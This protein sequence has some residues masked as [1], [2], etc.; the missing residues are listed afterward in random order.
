MYSHALKHTKFSFSV[1]AA[2]CSEAR[3][4][5]FTNIKHEGGLLEMM[6]NETLRRISKS[7]DDTNIL[8]IAIKHTRAK[9]V[10]CIPLSTVFKMANVTHIDFFILDVEG[11]ELSVLHSIDFDEVSFDVIVVETES[12][13]GRR[14]PSFVSD[15]IALLSSKGYANIDHIPGRNSW[16]VREGFIGSRRP[17]MY[18]L[19]FN[20]AIWS[21]FLRKKPKLPSSYF[22][23]CP[24]KNFSSFYANN[25]QN[26][27]MKYAN[28]E[29]LI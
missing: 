7:N 28:P 4:L 3:T 2:I 14:P 18:P 13:D 21:S 5:H 25:C 11:G 24:G 19:C 12:I 8:N 27:N 1:N 10:A 6:S 29:V 16:F 17:G 23:N 15:T 9:P 26:C 20:G 22:D